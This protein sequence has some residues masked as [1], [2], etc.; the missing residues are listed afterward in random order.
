M[1]NISDPSRGPFTVSPNDNTALT[2]PAV[3]L[4][5]G[6]TG[7]VTLK[8]VDGADVVFKNVPSGFILPVQTNFV[9]ATGTTATDIVGL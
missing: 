9:R 4:Y 8:G 7:H 1:A 5:V 3:A 2:K 6:T